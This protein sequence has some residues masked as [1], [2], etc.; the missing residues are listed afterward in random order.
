MSTINTDWAA[1]G[2]LDDWARNRFLELMNEIGEREFKREE[3]EEILSKNKLE[4]EN[5]GKLFSVLRDVGLINV[6]E[7]KSDSRRNIY[8]F[9]LLGKAKKVKGKVNR[10]ELIGILKRAAD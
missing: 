7:D 6:L 4:L 5:I 2:K 3:A 9:V 1:V 8:N 10:N